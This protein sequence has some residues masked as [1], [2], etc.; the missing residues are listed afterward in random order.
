MIRLI[1][2]AF[3]L[4]ALSGCL[5]PADLAPVQAGVHAVATQFCALP[6]DARASIEQAYHWPLGSVSLACLLVK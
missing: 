5:A 3:A 6:I 4:S 1:P 2:A